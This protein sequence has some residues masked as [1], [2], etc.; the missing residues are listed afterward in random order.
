MCVTLFITLCM[1]VYNLV[2]QVCSMGF[3]TGFPELLHRLIHS[4]INRSNG[5]R[6]PSQDRQNLVEPWV[7][8]ALTDQR[9]SPEQ[10]SPVMIKAT[11]KADP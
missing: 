3:Y 5:A 6:R 1:K 8:G 11:I 7:S 10:G 2:R 4:L 9:Q